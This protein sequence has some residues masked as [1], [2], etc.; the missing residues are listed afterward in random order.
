[1]KLEIG[2]ESGSTLVTEVK[3]G[4]KLYNALLQKDDIRFLGLEKTANRNELCL[5]N[6]DKVE[7]CKFI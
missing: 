7:Y 5:I 6:M 3:G 4:Y 2:F 1:M